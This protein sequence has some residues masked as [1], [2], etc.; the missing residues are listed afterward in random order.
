MV[1]DGNQG[2]GQGVD[3][4]L[5]LRPLAPKVKVSTDH[6][7]EAS[8]VKS[9]RLNQRKLM[10]QVMIIGWRCG[11]RLGSYEKNLTRI[12]MIYSRN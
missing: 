4:H 11:G 9:K 7:T 12:L 5:A 10:K 6:N 1:V 3:L 2:A 8:I